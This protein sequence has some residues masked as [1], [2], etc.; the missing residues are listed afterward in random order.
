MGEGAQQCELSS[1]QFNLI[2]SSTSRDVQATQ[3]GE[4]KHTKT[5]DENL[6]ESWSGRA[7]GK[8]P[9]QRLNKERKM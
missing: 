5:P 1:F 9:T 3:R 7:G 6:E 4:M 8:E 2:C